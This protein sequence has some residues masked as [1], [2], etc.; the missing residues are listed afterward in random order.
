MGEK[1]D[2]YKVVAVRKPGQ[3]GTKKLVAKYGKR[4][5]CLRYVYD[6][7]TGERFKTIELIQIYYG[8]DPME[9]HPDELV[10]V[11]LSMHE[12]EL[13]AKIKELGGRWDSYDKMWVLRY[14]DVEKLGLEKRQIVIKEEAAEYQL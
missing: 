9:F 3:K 8:L 11:H 1:L 7:W 12:V 4:F 14:D 6:R 13:R 2:R 10:G 5:R